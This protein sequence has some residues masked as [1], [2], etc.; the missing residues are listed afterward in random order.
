VS[1]SIAPGEVL[2][3]SGSGAGKSMTAPH[4]RLIEAPGRIGGRA[5]LEGER[6]D[7]LPSEAMRKILG[8]RSRDLPGSATSLNRCTRSP[9]LTETIQT[10]LDLSAPRQES[11]RSISSSRPGSGAEHRSITIPQFSGGMRQRV[12]IALAL[13]AEPK[14]IVADEPTTALDVSIQAQIIDAAQEALS[15][16]WHRSDA[17][18]THATSRDRRSRRRMYAGRIAEIAPSRRDP[19][20]AHPLHRR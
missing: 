4:H 19:S 14:L 11:A 20:S 13:A 5:T 15:R 3:S 17:G 2:A 9:A 1:F 16:P 18:S 8:A 7:N 6:I 10:H 12:V